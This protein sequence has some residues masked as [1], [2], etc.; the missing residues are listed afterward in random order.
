MVSTIVGRESELAATRAFIDRAERGAGLVLDG[1]AGIGKST[2]WLAAVAH[3]RARGLRVLA[4]RATE[5]ERGF[6]HVGLGDLFEGVV[7]DLL[8]RL[9]APRRRAL[10]V[11]LLLGEATEEPVDHRAVAVAIRD[12]LQLLSAQTPVLIAVDDV[13]WLDPASSNALAF[14]LR[15][16]APGQVVVLLARRHITDGQP[17]GIE[18]ALR[19]DGVELV[20]VGPLSV[21]AIHR[22]LRDRFQRP[23]ARQSLLAI[24]ERAGGNPF[25]A[26]ELARVLP[27]DVDP[28]QPLP[29]PDT[30]DQLVR[31]RIAALPR[32]TRDAL[33][34]ASALG[35][36]DVAVLERSGVAMG[37]LEPA[38]TAHLIERDGE[39][40]RFTHPLL[41]SV[42]YRD[43]GD[44]RQRVHA[45]LARLTDDPVAGARHLALSRDLPDAAVAAVLDGAASVA[46]DRGASA[47]A[48]EL[49]E[50]ALRLTPAGAD[51]RRRRGLAAARAHLA[52]GEWTRARTIATDL[53]ADT[54]SPPLRAEIRLFLSEFEH[55]DLAVP[56]LEQALREASSNAPLETLIRIRLAGSTRFRKGFAAALDDARAAL[57]RAAQLEDNELLGEALLEVS[58]LG[59][60]V[61][62]GKAGACAERARDLAIAS[63]DAHLLRA[64]NLLVAGS[65]LDSG[66]IDEA[67][68]ILE[69]EYRDWHERDELF[70]A[71][72][73]WS[74]AWVEL[75]AGRWDVAADVAARAHEVRVQYGVERNQ[76]HI[77]I[78]WIA[79]HRGQLD[80]ALQE[81]ERGLALCEE[82]VGFHPPLLEAVPGLVA[83]WA[84]DAAT[85]AGRFAEADRQAVA[86]GWGAPESRPWTADHAEAL[87]ELG[88]VDEAV[89]LIDRWEGDATRLS[90]ARVLANVTRCRGLVAAAQGWVDEAT[91]LLEQ[92]GAQHENVGDTFGCARAQLALGIVR[93]RARQKR[94]AREAIETALAGFERLGAATWVERARSEQGRSGGRTSSDG[95]TAAERRVAVLV[96]AG[97][98]NREVAAELFLGERTVA[99][100]LTHVYAKLGVRSRTELARRLR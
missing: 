85:A 82:Q 8:P 5:A 2:L 35:T 48:A 49:A 63:G 64:A 17:T 33:A 42:L 34:L 73:L 52:A 69:R 3:A 97:R 50:H 38:L 30:L 60:R 6:A 14:A 18:Q 58:I 99:G 46:A 54:R 95:L 10:E 96:A 1:E 11:V 43:L 66:S 70:G 24:H 36:P 67:R 22:L 7:D 45:T 40:F 83:L 47:V 28:L 84:G 88:V 90:R 13:Q 19:P 20:R 79:V 77:P 27:D 23:F 15:R 26:L 37:V 81:A 59:S 44:E 72:V 31:S 39:T 94:S 87:L 53:L 16:T 91:S 100:H 92:A 41:S 78:A 9:P 51:E 68:S 80:V 76:D 4:A 93:R 57:D 98:T 71:E 61:G 21:G 62:D 75:W 29:V 12:A 56:V 25:Y 86:L 74:L 55:D 65:H 89:R 32:Q